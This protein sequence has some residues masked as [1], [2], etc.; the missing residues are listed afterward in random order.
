MKIIQSIILLSFISGFALSS[1]IDKLAE[2]LKY[3][4]NNGHKYVSILDQDVSQFKPYSLLLNSNDIRGRFVNLNNLDTSAGN[5]DF[6]IV[7]KDKSLEFSEILKIMN[8]RNIQKSLLAINEDE[9]EEF[10]VRT[11]S[12][13]V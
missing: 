1:H 7:E 11:G 3:C 9:V 13:Y 4:H 10:K 8:K 12:G 2:I 6:L 5:L